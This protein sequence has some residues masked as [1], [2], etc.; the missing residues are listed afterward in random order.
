MDYTS[1]L[2]YVFSAHTSD[3]QITNC[4]LQFENLDP[5]VQDEF[6]RYLA[7]RG[8]NESL[9]LF[10]PDYA[11]HKEQLVRIICIQL[12]LAPYVCML[13]EYVRWL[14]DVKSFIEA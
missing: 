12:I 8:I 13:Q 11:E 7:E 3:E 5:G 1:D 14:K 6:E 4:D 2:Q 9:A 10:I